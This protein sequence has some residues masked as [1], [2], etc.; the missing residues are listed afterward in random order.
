MWIV[1]GNPPMHLLPNFAVK[2]ELAKTFDVAFPNFIIVAVSVGIRNVGDANCPPRNRG[3]NRRA[4]EIRN[5]KACVIITHPENGDLFDQRKLVS[6][7]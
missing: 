4:H 2:L 5:L 3:N 1:N 6:A 7:I